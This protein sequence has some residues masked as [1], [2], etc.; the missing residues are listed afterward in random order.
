MKRF[1]LA[2]CVTLTP[3][4]WFFLPLNVR[5]EVHISGSKDAMVLEA[6]NASLR[7]IADAF[8]SA[9]KT[10]IKLSLQTDRTITGTYSGSVRAVLQRLLEGNDYVARISAD[11]M[12]I[13]IT[14]P[15]MKKVVRGA[16]AD[17]DRPMNST[18]NEAPNNSGHYGWGGSR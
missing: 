10:K 18:D 4:A 13:A 16:I 6:K 8:G 2:V 14:S 3:I 12:S 7:E 15:D 5:A 9:F 1:K 17:P 11:Q